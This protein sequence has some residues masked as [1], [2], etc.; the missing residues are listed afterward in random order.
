MLAQI[1][2]VTLDL[3]IIDKPAQ[4]VA[5]ACTSAVCNHDIDGF[6]GQE[7]IRA[8]NI[9]FPVVDIGEQDIKLHQR[10]AGVVGQFEQKV[11]GMSQLCG[12]QGQ[13]GSEWQSKEMFHGLPPL[14]RPVRAESSDT[15][16]HHQ[17]PTGGSPSI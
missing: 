5:D 10:N 17:V 3:I 12:R 1:D 8:Q 9:L 6:T 14:A 16:A 4:N 15:R 11:F 2:F 7:H 13:G